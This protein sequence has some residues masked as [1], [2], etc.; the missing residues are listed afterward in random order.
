MD[1]QM[2]RL[3]KAQ[4]KN[5]LEKVLQHPTYPKLLISDK[6]NIYLISPGGQ[7]VVSLDHLTL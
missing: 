1:Q 4:V 7:S 5:R 6:V 2:N 3:W